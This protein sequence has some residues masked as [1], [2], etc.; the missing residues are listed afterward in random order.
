MSGSELPTQAKN[1]ADK[2]R[3]PNH[4]GTLPG[5]YLRFKAPLDTAMRTARSNSGELIDSAYFPFQLVNIPIRISRGTNSGED[6]GYIRAISKPHSKVNRITTP[7]I[8]TTNRFISL[9]PSDS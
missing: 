3:I 6:G 1:I 9:R 7:R 2:I 5:G 4:I 8:I